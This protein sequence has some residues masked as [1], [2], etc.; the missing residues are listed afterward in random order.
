MPAGTVVSRGYLAAANVDGVRGR[1]RA[2]FPRC[3]YVTLDGGPALVLHASGGDHT[4]TSLCPAGATSG[5]DALLG[6]VGGVRLITATR[7]AA[8]AA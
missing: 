5:A 4:P 2:T 1:V 6:V 7:T 3:A 8:V